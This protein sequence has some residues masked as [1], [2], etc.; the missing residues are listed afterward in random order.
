MSAKF[1]GEVFPLEVTG[2]LGRWGWSVGIQGRRP[3]GGGKAAAVIPAK[4]GIHWGLQPES[5]A[6]SK[7]VPAFA[8][9]TVSGPRR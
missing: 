5:A 9:T 4:A 1:N 8:G 6:D 2:W 3:G 7:W